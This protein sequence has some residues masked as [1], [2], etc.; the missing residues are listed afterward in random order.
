MRFTQ[1]PG[2]IRDHNDGLPHSAAETD[3]GD[4]RLGA[5]RWVAITSSSGI[6]STGEKKCMPSTRSGARASAAI[7]RIGIVEVLLAK[8][9]RDALPLRCLP[10]GSL[11]REV[12]VYRLD[13]E[14]G[15]SEAAVVGGS[16]EQAAQTI[17]L[18]L[19]DPA[20]LH[21]LRENSRRRPEPL[22]PAAARRP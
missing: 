14:I 3:G 21:P 7:S 9:Y 1:N 16:G 22:P 6:F 15:A 2:M 10:D 5:V 17:E 11:E 4:D 19:R 8:S 12:L 20:S 13:D 18:W